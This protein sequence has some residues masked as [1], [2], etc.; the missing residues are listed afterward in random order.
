MFPKKV[1]FILQSY[2]TLIFLVLSCTWDIRKRRLLLVNVLTRKA[3]VST[4]LV[5][6]FP[7]LIS[8]ASFTYFLLNLETTAAGH[9]IM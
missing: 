7:V 4:F 9:G 6:D 1:I 5:Q 8:V 2:Y 3:Q